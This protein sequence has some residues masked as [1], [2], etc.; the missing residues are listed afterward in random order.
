MSVLTPGPWH[1]KEEA[2]LK[3]K[4]LRISIPLYYSAAIFSS[5][6]HIKGHTGSCI[7]I[8]GKNG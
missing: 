4:G 5:R 6:D 2:L 1:E 8:N 7:K 3:I